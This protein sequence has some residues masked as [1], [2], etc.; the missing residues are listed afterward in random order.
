[1][2]HRITAL[3]L[4]A[5]AG[6]CLVLWLAASAPVWAD[7]DERGEPQ[8]QMDIDSV[9]FVHLDRDE[10]E[11]TPDANDLLSG[12][13]PPEQL[14]AQ[15]SSNTDW[16]LSIAGSMAAWDGPWA[17]PVGDI[18]WRRAGEGSYTPLATAAAEVQRGAPVKEF[19]VCLDFAIALDMA[20][21]LAGTY[22]YESVVFQV[23]AQ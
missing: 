18:L 15:V 22:R 1:M 21:D 19:D 17:K 8:F 3:G 2:K 23:S 14:T 12:R 5:T 4:L 9:M 6:G 7:D 11:F 13:T 16:V 20:H 10:L